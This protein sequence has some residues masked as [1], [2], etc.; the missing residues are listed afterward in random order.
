MEVSESGMTGQI[1]LFEY[2]AERSLL[3]SLF[4]ESRLYT[5]GKDYQELLRFVA[6]LR[7]FAPFNAML[8]Q[9][10]KPG[11]TYAASAADWLQ[12]FNR[13]PKDDARPLLILWPF[14]PV[15]LVYDIQD[16]EGDELPQDAFLF[17]ASGDMTSERI[18]KFIQLIA[19]TGIPTDYFDAGD[20]KAGYI[21]ATRAEPSEGKA[22]ISY[23]IKLNRNHSPA[24]QFATLV[25]ELSHLYLGHLGEDKPRKIPARR[26]LS[27]EEKE[28]EAE[29]AAYIVCT[30]N[31]VDSRS[32]TYLRD[33]V[34]N[35]QYTENL[36]I[37]QVMR[38]AGKIETL[39]G[40][41]A[42][43]TIR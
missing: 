24:T 36:D 6:A 11:L 13:V 31:G 40:L 43:M 21:R 7:N 41:S 4:E 20:G 28:L 18:E 15:A 2:E 26:S 39:L 14:G 19:K 3:D 29:S 35:S 34:K 42:K 9:I 33:Y 38:A 17:P 23:K 25:H 1:D 8:L 27:H 12:R 10:Q 30:R 5:T 37:Y 22:G 16:T 32:Q